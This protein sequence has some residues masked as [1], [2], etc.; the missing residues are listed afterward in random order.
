MEWKQDGKTG[1]HFAARGRREGCLNMGRGGEDRR[2]RCA[3]ALTWCEVAFSPLCGS[4]AHTHT[5]TSERW[6]VWG[7]GGGVGECK[8]YSTTPDPL[9][10]I[11]EH[12]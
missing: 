6:E 2:M 8:L 4:H 9:F 1:L 7:E 3:C 5:H 11:E 10:H 12:L